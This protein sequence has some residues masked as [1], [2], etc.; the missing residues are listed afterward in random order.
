MRERA[1]R[2]GGQLE[3]KSQT[4]AGTRVSL[5]VKR[6]LPQTKA[7]LQAA[8]TSMEDAVITTDAEGRVT[9]LN[10]A[11]EVLTGWTHI[12]AVGQEVATVYNAVDEETGQALQRLLIDIAC[13]GEVVKVNADILLIA[14]GGKQTAIQD[15]AAPIQ[16]IGGHTIGVVVVFHDDTDPRNVRRRQEAV[17]ARLREGLQ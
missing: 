15:S 13:G 10:P 2:I 7:W 14:K 6:T 16:D 8:L 5:T 4:G 12:E 9:Y 11:A 17:I 1:E 3:I